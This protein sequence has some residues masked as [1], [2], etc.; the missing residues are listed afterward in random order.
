MLN[1]RLAHYGLHP[2]ADYAG[3]PCAGMAGTERISAAY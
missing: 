1:L 3:L 2:E